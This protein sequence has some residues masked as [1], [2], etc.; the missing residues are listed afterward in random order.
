MIGLRLNYLDEFSKGV[1]NQEEVAQNVKAFKEQL[2]GYLECLTENKSC[3]ICTSKYPNLM[4]PLQKIIELH[5]SEI[6]AQIK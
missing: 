2:K 5:T 4:T 3:M 6:N 1:I